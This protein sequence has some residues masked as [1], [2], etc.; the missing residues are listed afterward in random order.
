MSLARGSKEAEKVS[1]IKRKLMKLGYPLTDDGANKGVFG[2][3]MEAAV[4]DFQIKNDLEETGIVDDVTWFAISKAAIDKDLVPVNPAYVE[5]KKYEGQGEKNKGFIAFMSG[6]WAKAGLPGYKTIVGSAFAW[7][8]LF[9]LAM[10]TQ[11]GQKVI[12]GAAGAKNWSKYGVE[13][14]Y[15]HNGAPKG[16]V[17]HINHK[18][19]C[20]SW[21]NNHVAFLDADCTAEDLTK[22]GGVIPLY[23]G[24]QSDKVKRS[25]F[26]NRE[27]CEVRWPMEVEPPGKI[28][29]SVGC[30]GGSG[31]ESTK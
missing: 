8:G 16:A 4:G 2:P 26:S 29:E 24:N 19:N 31:N 14:D 22:S 30:N 15:K 10:N 17:V 25:I 21:S 23:G 13:I 28:T 1:D 5:A 7:C 11:V 3:K 20:N 9:V 18:G 12:T 27:I 6:F